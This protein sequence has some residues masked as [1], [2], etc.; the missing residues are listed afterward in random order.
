[1]GLQEKGAL[2]L[3]EI[4]NL[5]SV[6]STVYGEMND[7]HYSINLIPYGNAQIWQLTMVLDNTLSTDVQ[8]NLKK[9]HKINIQ[10]S[11]LNITSS[12]KTIV[13]NIV[14]QLPISKE[15]QL[16]YFNNLLTTLTNALAKEEIKNAEKCCLCGVD[17]QYEEPSYHVYKGLY[18]NL[19]QSCVDAAYEEQQRE[20]EKE[21]KNIKN[22]PLSI[23][24]AAVGAI[25]G[26]IPSAISIFGFGWLFGLL[27]AICPVCSFFGYK[28]GKAPLR[29]YSTLIA[30]VCSL[31]A[32]AGLII[33]AGYLVA[34]AA[35]VSLK[36]VFNDAELGL[37][38]LLAQALLF[39]VIGIGCAWGYI[40]KTK[41]GQVRK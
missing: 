21:N 8:L 9:V 40:T 29:W 26:I 25:V 12:Y 20:I 39:D 11:A 32:T 36:E 38:G 15:K 2:R 30:A 5:K 37:G 34:L 24:L 23:I 4:L 22:L 35:N 6:G 13:Y 33:L 27:F 18:V 14:L 10:Y 1:M 16:N 17:N 28:L 41:S 7:Y 31:L 3:A 19:H